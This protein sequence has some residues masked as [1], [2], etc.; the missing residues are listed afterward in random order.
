[1]TTDPNSPWP[2]LLDE[3]ALALDAKSLVLENWYQLALKLGVPRKDSWMFERPSSQSPTNELFQYLE[4]SRPQ[5][6]LKKLK[7]SLHCINRMD[8][9]HYLTHHYLEGNVHCSRNY[10][11][12]CTHWLVCWTLN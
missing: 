6:T 7:E 11:F 8:L 4:A 3:I 1:M 2:S 5:M 10:V 12:L 9:L